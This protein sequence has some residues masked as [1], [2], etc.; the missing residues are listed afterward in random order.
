MVDDPCRCRRRCWRPSIRKWSEV[1]RLES[2]A[3]GNA[4]SAQHF[5]ISQPQPRRRE[6]GVSNRL[7][8]PLIWARGGDAGVGGD[9]GDRAFARWGRGGA[10]ASPHRSQGWHAAK[11][12][13]DAGSYRTEPVAGAVAGAHARAASVG[14][15]ALRA[16]VAAWSASSPQWS[17]AGASAGAKSPSAPN[18]LP[19]IGPLWVGCRHG[20]CPSVGKGVEERRQRAGRWSLA[21]SPQAWPPLS[22]PQASHRPSWAAR[23]RPPA[24]PR[25]RHSCA[26]RSPQR[27]RPQLRSPLGG[28]RRAASLGDRRAALGMPPV[29]SGLR[30]R[31]QSPKPQ[32]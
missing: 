14:L 13:K 1:G 9:A 16:C 17:P 5:S 6:R 28:Q 31:R 20:R 4:L 32:S 15:C 7:C 12:G 22:T 24:P 25:Q 26:M 3:G 27:P 11:A 18:P 29:P 2:G 30:R 10:I 8:R 23:P 21:L 19:S